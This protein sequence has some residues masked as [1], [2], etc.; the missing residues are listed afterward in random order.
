M[1]SNIT[2]L[3]D[4]HNPLV[5]AAENLLLLATQLR[6]QNQA[7]QFPKLYDAT[8]DE[9]TT[10][11]D[12]ATK[13]DCNKTTINQARFLLCALIDEII[14]SSDWDIQ[15]RWKQKNLVNTFQK[16]MADESRFFQILEQAQE[17]PEDHIDLL[18]LGYLCLSLGYQ[19]TYHG[20]QNELGNFIDRLHDAI[21]HERGEAMT[22]LSIDI[23]DENKETTPWRLPP[24]WL[25]ILMAAIIL[26]VIF[27]PYNKKLNH[28]A[29]PV[30]QSIQQIPTSDT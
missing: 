17:A 10:F 4:M 18:E 19:G 12:R 27:I 5:S 13:A 14:L 9:I 1:D 15:S 3:M 25:T 28:D 8:C 2:A 30:L 22:T 20:N 29:L 6:Q 24:I 21:R 16:K 7:P 26:L 11:E 23:E